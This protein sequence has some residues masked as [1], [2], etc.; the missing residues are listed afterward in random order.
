M[1]LLDKGSHVT[2]VSYEFCKEMG[3]KFTR[4]VNYRRYWHDFIE[5]LCCIEAKLS[6]PSGSKSFEVEA[7]LLVLLTTEYHKRVPEAIGTSITNLGITSLDI[8]GFNQ[9][10]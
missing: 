6:L 8:S 3:S 2:H 10:S 4:L 7:L 1:A 9:C 5:Y